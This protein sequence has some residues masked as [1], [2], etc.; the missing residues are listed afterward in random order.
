M[1]VV[2]LNILTVAHVL[3]FVVWYLTLRLVSFFEGRSFCQ[4]MKQM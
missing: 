3:T 4:N 1:H 2:L